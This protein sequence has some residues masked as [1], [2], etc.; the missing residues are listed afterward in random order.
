MCRSGLQ[1]DGHLAIAKHVHGACL[2]GNSGAV[3]VVKH[4]VS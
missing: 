3:G 2:I 4:M 1:N